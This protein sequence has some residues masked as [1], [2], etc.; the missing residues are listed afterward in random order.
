M[1]VGDTLIMVTI[2][3]WN[4]ALLKGTVCVFKKLSDLS[5]SPSNKDT[6]ID[7]KRY[8]CEPPLG[9]DCFNR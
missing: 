8:S 9:A 7:A 2:L 4:E 6:L 3:F 5:F 1:L